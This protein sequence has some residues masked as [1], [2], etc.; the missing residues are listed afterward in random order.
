MLLVFVDELIDVVEKK[1]INFD[2]EI[3][4][5]VVIPVK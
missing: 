3:F 4:V 1:L 2:L 5:G